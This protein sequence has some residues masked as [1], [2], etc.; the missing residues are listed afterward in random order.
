MDPK[1]LKSGRG[2]A[3]GVV[4]GHIIYRIG[5]GDP[6]QQI[7]TSAAIASLIA[8]GVVLIIERGFKRRAAKRGPAGR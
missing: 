8:V 5:S 6:L 4:F 1:L 7:V 2:A 3:I